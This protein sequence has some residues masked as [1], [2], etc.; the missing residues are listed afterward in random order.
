MISPTRFFSAI[1]LITA[2]YIGALFL[3]RPA[4]A[5]YVSTRAVLA[6]YQTTGLI[7]GTVKIWSGS[8]TGNTSG[9]WSID[10]SNAGF[11]TILSCIPEPMGAAAT[12]AGAVYATPVVVSTTTCSGTVTQPATVSI[13]G[14]LTVS[15]MNT[16]STVQILAIGI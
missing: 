4:N 15:L 12:A 2:V 6:G 3:V 9:Q 5:G 16:A 1:G 7:Q 10:Y 13:L 14:L 11:T 8:T